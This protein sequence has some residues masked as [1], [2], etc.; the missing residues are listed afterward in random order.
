M[1]Q[2]TIDWRYLP[3]VRPIFQA[4]VREYPPN[5]IMAKHMVLMYLHFRIL[6]FPSIF[7]EVGAHSY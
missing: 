5:I 7:E 2:E 3:Y 6:E 4:Y 1:Q